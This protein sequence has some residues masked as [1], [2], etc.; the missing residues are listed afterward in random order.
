MAIVLYIG[1]GLVVG[2][3]AH[4]TKSTTSSLAGVVGSGGVGGAIGGFFANLVFSDGIVVDGA[5]LA[6][7]AI[8]AIVAVL[9]VRIADRREVQEA[10][11]EPGPDTH[12]DEADPQQD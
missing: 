6:G 5:G 2:A 1:I 4:F 10:A 11:V 7:S 8:L 9:V 3:L 12:G